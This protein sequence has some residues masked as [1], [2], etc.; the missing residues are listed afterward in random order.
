MSL[1]GEQ[2]ELI[3]T[4]DQPV[5]LGGHIVPPGAALELVLAVDFAPL[6]RSARL[7][8]GPWGAAGWTIEELL[9]VA[10]ELRYGGDSL[11]LERAPSSDDGW[12]DYQTVP[13][14]AKHTIVGALKVRRDVWSPQLSNRRDLL[15]YLPPSYETGSQRYPVIYMH[16]GQNLFDDMTSFAGEWQVDETMHALSERGLEAIVVGI[17]NLGEQ[18]MD[19]Y[20]PFIQPGLGGGRGAAYLAFVVETIKPLIDRDFRTLP[21]REHTGVLGSSMGGLISLYAYFSRPDTFGFAGVLSPALW[22]AR[23]A[24]FPYIAQAPFVPGTLYLDM[25]TAEGPEVLADA[26]RMRT[27]LRQKGYRSPATLRYVEERGAEHAEAV[28]ANRLPIALK[29]LLNPP[30]RTP[31]RRSSPPQ[32]ALLLDA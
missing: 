17:P 19:E 14:G 7:E 10:H 29:F 16:D 24:I 31:R 15:V 13:D 25:G 27:L 20:S 30:S 18:R 9:D 6:A 3:N 1:A 8:R 21:D 32:R 28:W 23:R 2:I 26:R 11:V 12:L 5:T 4:S 22:F